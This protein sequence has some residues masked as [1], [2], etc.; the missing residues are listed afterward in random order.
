MDNQRILS[1]VLPA[2]AVLAFLT[3]IIALAPPSSTGGVTTYREVPLIGGVKERPD[4]HVQYVRIDPGLC[5][6]YGMR[7]ATF[8]AKVDHLCQESNQG[9]QK[10]EALCRR[11]AEL[12]AQGQCITGPWRPGGITDRTVDSEGRVTGMVVVDPLACADLAENYDA[13]VQ[14]T[15]HEEA[16]PQ[17]IAL[18]NPCTNAAEVATRTAWSPESPLREY[19]RVV[20]QGGDVTGSVRGGE[21]DQ[22][23]DVRY[24]RCANGEARVSVS[25]VAICNTLS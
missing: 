13:I 10:N 14:Q 4:S 16:H 18:A 1:S 9:R 17:T 7:P 22:A 20:F 23:G 5:Y 3:I 6:L 24:V 19:A 15:V 2:I 25:G 12:D 21:E 11:Q 8:Y